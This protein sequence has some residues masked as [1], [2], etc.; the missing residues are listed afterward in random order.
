MTT[1]RG[2]LVSLGATLVAVSRPVHAQQPSKT[3]RIGFFDLTSRQ[4]VLETGRYNASCSLTI[5]QSLL[6]QASQVIQ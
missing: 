3:A 4:S 5:P 6:L 1:R 2:F